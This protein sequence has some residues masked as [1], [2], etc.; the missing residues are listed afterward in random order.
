MAGSAIGFLTAGIFHLITIQGMTR[1]IETWSGSVV[2]STY[3]PWWRAEWTE[4]ETYTDGNGNEQTRIVHKSED[5]PEHWTCYV[6]YG[7]QK[8]DYSISREEFEDFIN[9]FKCQPAAFR[10]HKADFAKGD[11]ND[12]QVVNKSGVL[13]PANDTYAFENRIKAAPSV[14][15]Y[16]SVPKTAKVF[17]YPVSRSWRR[18]ARLVGTAANEFSIGAWDSMNSELGPLKKVNLIVVGFPEDAD[19]SLAHDQEAKWIG[20]KKNDVVICYGGPR[21]DGKPAWSY[22][23]GWTDS[24]LIKSNLETLFIDNA[25]SNDLLCQIKTEVLANYKIKDWSQ[26]DYITVEPPWWSF[27]ILM[28]AMAAAQAGWYWFA[29]TNDMKK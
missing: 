17:E 10:P 5:H 26:F 7:R 27:I 19:S 8:A 21:M 18:S 24:T 2:S 4:I 1:D 28:A 3:H 22:V 25:P 16:H 6:S 14:F 11:P 12:Y 9:F 20:G 15:S 13:I 23:F 29:N